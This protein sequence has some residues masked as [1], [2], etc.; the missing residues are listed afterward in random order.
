MDLKE[1]NLLKRLCEIHAPS[2]N[3][4]ALKDFLLEYIEKQ[5]KNWKVQPDIFSGDHLQDCIIL[6][7]GKPRTAI[8]AHIDSIGFTVRYENQLIPIGGPETKTGYQLVGHDSLGPIECELQVDKENRLF[9]DFARPIETG[10]DLTFKCNFIHNNE[11][12]QSCYLDNRLGV[13]NALKVAEKLQDG[14]IAF[15]TYEEHGG[16]SMPFVLKFIQENFPV[17]QGLV[18]DI[19]WV[20][21]GVHHGEGVVISLRD[22]NIPRKAFLKKI[23]DIAQSTNIPYQLEVEAEGSSDG[24]EIQ[25]SPYP[26]DWCFIGAPESN[27]H[28]PEETVHINDINSMIALYSTLMEQL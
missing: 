6:K 11:Y 3:E 26:M 18:S 24:R 19:T 5:S 2:G 23:K 9:Y 13:F 17:Y 1:L 21:D 4:G 14:I 16:G 25:H 7:F 10:T 8:F 12:F 20:T 28:S 22:R 15:T 27:V